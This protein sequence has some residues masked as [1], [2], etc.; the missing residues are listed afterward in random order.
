MGSDLPCFLVSNG[1][2]V[3]NPRC[4]CGQ[5]QAAT[6]KT[7]WTLRISI[8]AARVGSDTMEKLKLR[9]QT[10]FQSTLPVWAATNA[11]RPLDDILRISIH[12]ARVGSDSRWH[13]GWR[14]LNSISIHA[15]RVGSDE[16]I[17]CIRNPLTI[18]IHAARVGSDNNITKTCLLTR[19]FNPRC[20]CGQRPS[21]RRI[22]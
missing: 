2:R 9:K 11:G 22:G 3:F 6:T 18:S 14:W 16:D 12:A 10:S 8:H 13:G 5:R 7:R 21:L 19:H 15:A 1:S 20:P 4:P 17:I